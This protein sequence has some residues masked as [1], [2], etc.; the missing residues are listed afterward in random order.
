M[1]SETFVAVAIRMSVDAF[2]APGSRHVALGHPGDH[3]RLPRRQRDDFER[4]VTEVGGE[5]GSLLSA[6]VRAG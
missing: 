2:G 5:L 4:S 3:R 6:E 1:P